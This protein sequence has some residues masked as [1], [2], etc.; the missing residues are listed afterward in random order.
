MVP[1]PE[2]QYVGQFY[3]YGSEAKKL[4]QEERRQKAKT[5][6]PLERLR[7]VQQVYVDPVA[8]FGIVVAVVMIVTMIIGAVHIQDA[9]DTYE[10]MQNHLTW[11]KTENDRL[12]MEYSA[13]YDLA[14][15]KD[16]AIALGMV[17]REEVTTIPVTVTLPKVMEEPSA[18]EQ[19]KAEVRWFIDGLFA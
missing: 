18:W 15:I 16:A 7:N 3:V 5:M 10:D 13:G 4:A 14:E 11:L 6:L 17:P 2:I 1:K 12:T 9:W 19:L 8:L